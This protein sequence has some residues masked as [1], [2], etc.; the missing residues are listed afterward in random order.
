MFF[1]QSGKRRIYLD[2][3]A[4][5]PVDDEVLARLSSWAIEWGNPSSIHVFGRGPKARLRD[6]RDLV[7]KAIAC[8]PLEVVFTAGGSEANN[9]ALKGTMA[10][11]RARGDQRRH[12][13]ISALEH[14]SLKRA[15]QSLVRD[16]AA[17]IE[18]IPVDRS[19][20]VK[21][22][23]VQS[24]LRPGQTLLV[25]VMLANN[26]TGV[27]QPVR[28]ITQV[29]HAAGALMHTDAVQALGKIPVSIRELDVDL[30]SFAAHK[31][32]ALKGA[33]ALFHRKGVALEALIDGGGQ[34]RFRRGGT[35]NLLAL[36]SFGYMCSRIGE[37]NER[38]ERM[39]RLRDEFESQVRQRIAGVSIT[40]ATSP[41]LPS[42]S[43]LV[44]PGVDGETLL[45][46]LDMDGFAVSTG[47]ACS[48][49]SPE[50]SPVLLAMG[51]SRDEAQAS[52]RVGIG[53]S[54][55]SSDLNEF[56]EALVRVVE[57]LRSLRGFQMPQARDESCD[58]LEQ[59]VE[60]A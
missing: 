5:T 48:S 58:V 59:V 27:L 14:P 57:R 46:A 32:Y 47:A 31:F 7:A 12:I 25:S 4:T 35:E 49:G 24:R 1:T 2:H 44:I 50:P 28:E 22:A 34:E 19:G 33:G 6:A 41:R 38:A 37:V 54:T 11:A 15:A 30:A 16:F 40:A 60:H 43:S 23:D 55:T 10:A 9:M 29:V 18:I 39:R 3:N 51:L 13:L 21:V 20:Q 36:S 8:S 45:M 53:W 52:L 42:T 17:E 26:E 56:L